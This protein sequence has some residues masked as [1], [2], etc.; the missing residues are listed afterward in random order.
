[1]T[2]KAENVI[3]ALKIVGIGLSLA[4][5]IVEGKIQSKE[6]ANAVDKALEAKG[7]S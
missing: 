7:K 2:I 6:I 1:M 3:K 5:T 4:T